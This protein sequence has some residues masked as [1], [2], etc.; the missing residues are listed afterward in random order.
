MKNQRQK[1]YILIIKYHTE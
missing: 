1:S